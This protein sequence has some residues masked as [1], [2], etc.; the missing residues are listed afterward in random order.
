MTE[1]EKHMENS[2]DFRRKLFEIQDQVKFIQ[3]NARGQFAFL[4]YYGLMNKLYPLL[5]ERG[6]YMSFT[7]CE[8]SKTMVCLIEDVESGSS[9]E[10]RAPFPEEAFDNKNAMA[11]YGKKNHLHK[12]VP[13][14]HAV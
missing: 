12:K 1:I 7:S 6:L 11:S 5:K 8:Y 13:N 3:T 9:K 4:N 14:M 10:C 2:R